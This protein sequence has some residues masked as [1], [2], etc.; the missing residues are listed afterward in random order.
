MRF[1][2][3]TNILAFLF[4]GNSQDIDNNVMSLLSDFENFPKTSSICV[5]EL[6]HL[7]QIGKIPISKHSPVKSSSDIIKWVEDSGIEI[8]YPNRKNIELYSSLPI[9]GDH[10]DPNDRLIIA[11]AISDKIPLVSSDRKF[12]RYINF[13]LNLIFNKR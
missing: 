10:R 7:C 9:L 13:G 11:Q 2:I 12:E 6:I 3:D 5:C 8:V 1:Y 4:L